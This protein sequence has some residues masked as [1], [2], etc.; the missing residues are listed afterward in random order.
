M[1]RG[2]KSA[3][4]LAIVP[5]EIGGRPA[6]LAELSGE[7]ADVW[8][9]TVN[10]M[11][12]GWF[13]EENF[14]ILAAYC[15][16]VVTLRHLSLMIDDFNPQWITEDYGEGLIRFGRLTALRERESRAAIAAARSL[17]IT[18]SSQMRREAAGRQMDGHAS[19]PKPW[20]MA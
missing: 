18:K 13:G 11:P 5:V 15:R 2:R 12:G 8:R 17:R 6:P 10:R 7:Q 14:A 4:E 1:K 20:E 9:D 16:H 19:G 3:A